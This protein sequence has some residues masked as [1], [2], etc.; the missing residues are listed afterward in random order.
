MSAG[1]G[2]CKT[3]HYHWLLICPTLI[4]I[5]PV[6]SS[7]SSCT[8]KFMQDEGSPLCHA[9]MR[10]TF[11]DHEPG[12]GILVHSITLQQGQYLRLLSLQIPSSQGLNR[13]PPSSSSSSSPSPAQSTSSSV[14]S[15]VSSWFSATW[16]WFWLCGTRWT[17]WTRCLH[18]RKWLVMKAGQVD[19]HFFA[20]GRYASLTGSVICRS[21][22]FRYSFLK[23]FLHAHNS[24]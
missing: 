23:S 3:W 20:F 2:A 10:S 15:E 22:S 14:P 5:L 17:F 11:Y 9:P 18:I 12:L 7:F 6:S 8:D 19:T 13:T 1:M 21:S 4:V 24:Q 16:S